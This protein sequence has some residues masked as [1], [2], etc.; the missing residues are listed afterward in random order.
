[1]FLDKFQNLIRQNLRV[2]YIPPEPD[3]QISES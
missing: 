1:M 3:I 2:E